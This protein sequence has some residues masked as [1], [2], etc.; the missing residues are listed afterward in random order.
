MFTVTIVLPVK[1]DFHLAKFIIAFADEYSAVRCPVVSTGKRD[2]ILVNRAFEISDPIRAHSLQ[3][4]LT[5]L[6]QEAEHSHDLKSFE[7]G[8]KRS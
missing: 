3:S 5:A 8:M 6:C 2:G 1:A 7:I 4:M